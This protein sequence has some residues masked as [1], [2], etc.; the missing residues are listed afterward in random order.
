MSH[1]GGLLDADAAGAARGVFDRL[2]GLV[3]DAVVLETVNEE[4]S[5]YGERASLLT[6]AD[7]KANTRESVRVPGG[8][9]ERLQ[10]RVALEAL[11]E[12]GSSF[13][14]WG[15]VCCIVDCEHGRGGGC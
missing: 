14:L 1:C 13:A 8:L 15:R 10:R 3:G 5:E 12:S 9:L 4:Q 2:F 6:G 11:R 7:T